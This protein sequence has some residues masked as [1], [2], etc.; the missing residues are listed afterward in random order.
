MRQAAPKT[1]MFLFFRGAR[2]GV[3]G[4]NVSLVARRMQIIAGSGVCAAVM[5][6][7][8]WSEVS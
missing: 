5:S 7:G 6:S 1:K 4:L 2:R 8:R 3:K